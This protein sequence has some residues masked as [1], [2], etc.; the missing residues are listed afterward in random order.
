MKRLTLLFA[1]ILF[2]LCT[3]AQVNGT[4]SYQGYLTDNDGEPVNDGE[5]HSF[6]FTFYNEGGTAVLSRTITSEVDKG[7]FSV[8][9]GGGTGDNSA[10]PTDIWDEEYTIGIAVDGGT[11]LTPRVPLTTVP[12][13]FQAETAN[14]VDGANISGS[15]DATQLSGTIA[16]GRLDTDLQDLADGE[17][18]G[19]KIGTGISADNITS[20]TLENTR[21]DAD[22]QD[23]ADGSLTGSKVGSGISGGNISDGTMT[24]AKI[25]GTIAIEDGGT[26]AAT[27]AAARTNLGLEIGSDVQAYDADLDDLADGSLSG[28]K[29][30]TGI[31]A[32]NITTGTLL[33]ARLDA[34]LQ[35]LADGELSGSLVGTGINAGNITT[36]TVGNG[37]LDA[38]LQDLA[39]GSLTGTLVDPDFGTQDIQTTGDLAVGGSGTTTLQVTHSNGNP[40]SGEGLSLLNGSARWTFAAQSGGEL[41]LYYG[42]SS[43]RGI[44]SNTDGAYT[45]SSDRRIKKNISDLDNILQ[46]VVQVPIYSYHYN[47]QQDAEQKKIGT[48][49]QDLLPIFPS[50]VQY[51]KENDFYTVNYS[52]LSAVAIKAIQEQQKI[53]D[54]LRE[55]LENT[56]EELSNLKNQG[57]EMKALL[58]NQEQKIE[59]LFELIGQKQPTNNKIAYKEKSK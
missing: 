19:D 42:T 59:Q 56:R 26:N 4:L 9:I 39:D 43:L 52:S 47:S 30:G 7:L 29:V 46:K 22:L 23:L 31:S 15:I 51:S 13:S 41:Y 32:D 36:G 6:V 55:A 35:D 50:M 37:R 2:T 21:L 14:N 54:E 45:N 1:S 48:I 40:S 38:D 53:I 10:L 20:G 34:Q 24:T 49:A 57:N 25:S 5:T 17:L 27:E 44:F 28:S 11:E 18:S 3:Y 16:N 33:N 8:I 58:Y 12:Y